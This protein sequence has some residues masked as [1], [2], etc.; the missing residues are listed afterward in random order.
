[1]HDADGEG[2]GDLDTN[3]DQFLRGNAA[4]FDECAEGFA[5]DEFG[6][7]LELTVLLAGVVNSKDVGMV[8]RAEC[9]G[10]L[11]EADALCENF[12]RHAAVKPRVMS[13][14]D[15]A[16]AAFTE[17]GRDFVFAE[18]HWILDCGELGRRFEVSMSKTRAGQATPA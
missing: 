12:D 8:K 18:L 14:V 5:I 11:L 6:D 13:S 16:R 3:V 2:V 9:L 4:T 1:M 15:F 10:F 7:D 17:F